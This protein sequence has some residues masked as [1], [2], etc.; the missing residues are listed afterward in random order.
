M[1]LKKIFRPVQY[2]RKYDVTH[3]RNYIPFLILSHSPL[4]LSLKLA[5]L[6]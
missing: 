4:T 5:F 1:L 6:S 3:S 2:A